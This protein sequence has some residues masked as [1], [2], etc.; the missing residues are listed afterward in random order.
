M[1]SYFHLLVVLALFSS[2][3]LISQTTPPSNLSGAELRTWLKTNWYDGKHNSLG[4]DGARKQMYGYVDKQADG[5]VYCVYSGFHQTAAFVSYLNPINCE[6]TIP[7]SWFGESSPMVADMF[8]LYPTHETVNGA[9]GSF[10]FTEIIDSQTTTWYIVNTSNSGLSTSSTIPTSNIDAY[11][12]L[13]SGKFEPRESHKG[14]LARSAFYFYTVYP[15]QAGAITQLAPLD[16]LYQWHLAD[17]VDAWEI[18]RN[19]RIAAKQGNR[20]PY[21]EYPDIACRA[22]GLTCTN[23]LAFTSS[24]V[25]SAMENQ[26]YNYAVTYNTVDETETLTCSTKPAWLTFTKDESANTATL[27]GT[28]AAGD[29]GQHTVTMTLTEG[30]NTE[31]Q[32]FTITVS[33]FSNVSNILDEPFTTCTLTNWLNVSKTSTKNWTCGTGYAWINGYGADVAS[34]DWLITPAYNLDNY[35]NEK[36]SFTTWT[37]YTDA[38]VVNP[39]V[40]LKYTTNY[41]GDPATTTWTTLAYTAPAENSVIETASG[42]I[43]VSAIAGTAV[44]FAFHYTSSGVGSSSSSSWRI[45]NVVLAAEQP[46]ATNEIEKKR[47]QVIPNPVNNVFSVSGDLHGTMIIYNINGAELHRTELEAQNDVSFLKKGFYF[48][49]IQTNEGSSQTLRF[50]KM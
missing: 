12:E 38:G 34:D 19:T 39:E 35:L 6:H 30:A 48:V 40:K 14:D 4:Y 2:K 49:K 5:Q 3:T 17:P 33:P 22:W 32:T 11:S 44:R 50:V 41:T 23:A 1:K 15:T 24:P 8:H 42:S 28:P 43:D 25:T 46:G 9:R 20:N 16:V 29:V 45:D 37:Q 47:Y 26:V 31:T 18:Q 13:G 10:P 27:T 21:I 36:L 7:Q